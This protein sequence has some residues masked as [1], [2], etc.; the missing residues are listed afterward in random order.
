M[1]NW[2]SR[3]KPP[4]FPRTQALITQGSESE[5]LAAELL[6][7]PTALM[8]LTLEDARVVVG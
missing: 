6:I 4:T 2:F 3:S 7:A 1:L 8:Q 5:D